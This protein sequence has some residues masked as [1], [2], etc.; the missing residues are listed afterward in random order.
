MVLEEA[1][2][3]TRTRRAGRTPRFVG[4]REARATKFPSTAKAEVSEAAR[5]QGRRQAQIAHKQRLEEIEGM[6]ENEW[7]THKGM[8]AE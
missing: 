3:D 5:A 8:F 2:A 6:T 7:D 4:R 1:P